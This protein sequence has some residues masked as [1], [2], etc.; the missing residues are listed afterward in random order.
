MGTSA[1]FPVVFL[2]VHSIFIYFPMSVL[3]L[4]YELRTWSFAFAIC[5]CEFPTISCE[6]LSF[7]FIF[8][9]FPMMFLHFPKM[10]FS[11]VFFPH[12]PEMFLYFLMV[13]Y[14]VLVLPYNC[15][16]CSFDFPIFQPLNV[17]CFPVP[18]LGF[19]MML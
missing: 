17:V 9:C 19:P 7:Q 4:S 18:L 12:V 2:C 5:S 11:A 8:L 15:P 1:N 10:L 3:I 6:V 13:S 14:G 16:V